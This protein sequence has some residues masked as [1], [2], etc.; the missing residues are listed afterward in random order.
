MLKVHTVAA[1][2]D[3]QLV[4]R[5]GFSV[6]VWSDR[7]RY[8]PVCASMSRPPWSATV[9]GLICP[10]GTP[11]PA[12]MVAPA[13][14]AGALLLLLVVGVGLEELPQADMTAP[15]TGTD[16]PTTAPR[17]RKSR[18]EIRPATNS[19]MTWFSTTPWPA[20]RWSSRPLS[21]FTGILPK[22]R[23]L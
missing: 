2:F 11:I 17:R 3:D 5:T 8:S 18:R 4:A 15:S 22:D 1:A 20:R 12:L 21:T 6:S 7:H 14:P 10:V 16:M 19:S 9:S 13:A 23:V